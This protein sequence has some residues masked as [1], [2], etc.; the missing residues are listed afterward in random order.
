MKWSDCL[1]QKVKEIKPDLER[2]KSMRQLAEKRLGEIN[3][4]RGN[5]PAEF[6]VEDYYETVKELITALLYAE[7]YKSYSHECLIL[8]L[9]KY[10]SQKILLDELSLIDQLRKLRHDIMYRGSMVAE[11]YLNRN[12]IKINT[13]ISKLMGIV[14]E[15]TN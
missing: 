8:F 15:K 9:E 5:T 14:V 13:I 10:Y 11:D 3:K 12:E 4:R 1:K 2:A 7:G 6:I